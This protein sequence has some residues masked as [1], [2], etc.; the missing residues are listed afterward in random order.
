MNPRS[1][2]GEEWTARS[3]DGEWRAAYNAYMGSPAWHAIRRRVMARSY[4]RC[5]GCGVARAT[6]V[7]HLTYEHMGSEL[8]WELVAVCRDCHSK[9]HKHMQKATR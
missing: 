5:E 1:R 4:G 7:H 8:L 3:T 6:D 2:R 9:C